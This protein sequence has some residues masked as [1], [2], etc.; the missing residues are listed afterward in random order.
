MH[1]KT[2]F[3]R[4]IREIENVFI[5]LKDGTRLA[6]RLWLPEDAEASPV[7]AILEYLPY[8]KNDGTALRDANRMPYFAGHGYAAVRVDMRGSGDSDGILYDEYLVQEQDDAL[9]VLEWL[10]QQPWCTGACGIIGISWGGFN[11]LQ[12]AARRPPQLKAI[13]TLC[14][15]DD[16]YADDVHYMGGCVLGSE[17]LP[18]ASTMLALNAQ[19]PDPR[20]VGERWREMWL[21]RMEQSPPFVEAWLTHQRRDSYW[22]H[23]SVCENFADIECAVYAVGGWADG[24]TN[25]VPRLLAGLSCPRKG[26]IGPWA[27]LYPHHAVPEPAI[28]FLQECLRWWDKW[29]K[30]IETG[31]MDEPMLRV[32]MQ[33]PVPPGPFVAARPG[34]WVAEE[35]WPSPRIEP[36]ALA[37][38]GP[39]T[40]LTPSPS[41]GGRRESLPFSSG[42]GAEGEGLTLKGLQTSGLTLGAWCPYGHVGDYALDQRGEDG[43]SLTFTSAPLEQPLEILGFPDVELDLAV[44]QPNAL[45]SVRL[46]DVAPDGASLLV[47]WGLLNLTHRNSHEFPEPVEPGRRDTVTVRLNAIAHHFPAGHRLRVGVSPTNWPHAWPSPQPVTLQLF[48]ENCRLILPVRPTSAEDAALPAFAPPEGAAPLPVDWLRIPT[49]RYTLTQDVITQRHTL[50]RSTKDG[51]FRI[52]ANGLEVES[53]GNDHFSIT[54]GQPLSAEVRCERMIRIARGG[55]Q[56]R[57]QT[58]SVMTSTLTHFLVT[59]QLEAF[60]GEVRVFAKTWTFSVPRDWV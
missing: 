35:V 56:T 23:G 60:E 41:P 42:G 25:A 47:S 1:I 5:P 57:V 8:R 30:G 2:H 14:S 40:A 54:E 16:R 55:W 45:L 10:A 58:E 13:I 9:E 3:P 19:P 38:N 15:T 12:I 32:W 18:W 37:L 51:C 21:E 50:T 22:K 28:G 39:L 7:P 49:D 43:M 33:E 26:L 6:A 52:R 17:M 4:P 27:H 36:L 24:Y 11:G 59:N 20:F 53:W 48:P 29:L 31:V 44:D 34:R 46:C